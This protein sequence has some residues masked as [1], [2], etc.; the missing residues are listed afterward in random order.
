MGN[1]SYSNTT[2]TL[3]DSCASVS[4]LLSKARNRKIRRFA[5]HDNVKNPK[6]L[7]QMITKCEPICVTVPIRKILTLSIYIFVS[8]QN[9]ICS[10]II[11]G[12]CQKKSFFYV[13]MCVPLPA[14]KVI[15]FP[16]KAELVISVTLAH[17]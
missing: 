5:S 17:E 6:R 16:I 12:C 14:V 3:V 7:I 9:N 1:K 13:P 2:F 8:Y 4:I 11:L 15:P 10:K